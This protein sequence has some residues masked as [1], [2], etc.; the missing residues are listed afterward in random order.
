MNVMTTLH[1]VVQIAGGEKQDVS[2]QSAWMHHLPELIGLRSV[3]HGETSRPEKKAPLGLLEKIT[4]LVSR[5]SYQY[6]PCTADSACAE[7][8]E[9]RTTQFGWWLG[10]TTTLT[11]DSRELRLSGSQECRM[12]RWVGN[13]DPSG[14]SNGI[15]RAHWGNV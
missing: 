1:E 3:L 8:R 11:P 10:T 9:V 5:P 7:L 12:L 4:Q 2:P 15:G 14:L 13:L 6:M